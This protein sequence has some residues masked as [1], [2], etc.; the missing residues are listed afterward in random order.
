MKLENIAIGKKITLA[1]IVLALPIIFM[2]GVIVNG[3]KELNDFTKREIAGV[4]YLRP[5]QKL[6]AIMAAQPTAKNEL[7]EALDSLNK[8]EQHDAG[9]LDVTK[10][11]K[12]LVNIAQADKI[13]ESLAGI[14]DLIATISDNSNI[15]LDSDGDTYFIGDILVNQISGIMLQTRNLIK[16][17]HDLEIAKNDE[18]KIAY[19]ASQSA[20]ATGGNNLQTEL[21]KAIKA[22]KDGSVK[23]SLEAGGHEISVAIEN[24][25]QL[26][27][28]PELSLLLPASAQLHSK[29]VIF[30]ANASGLMERLLR[31][32]IASFNSSMMEDLSLSAFLTLI[33]SILSGMIILSITRPM[34]FM[35]LAAGG[36][37]EGKYH[38]AIEG[39]RRRDEIGIL[40]R[41]IDK[42]RTKIADYSGQISAIDKSQAVI[43]FNMDGTIIDANQN[44]LTTMGYN[45]DE[46]RGKHHRMFVDSLQ[47]TSGEYQ[48]FW[49]N[50]N[51][52]H[53][54]IGDVRRI[55]KD[56]REVWIRCSYNPIT[57]PD[58]KPFKVVKYAS[59]VTKVVMANLEN[60]KGMKESVQVLQDIAAG[61]LTNN[62]KEEYHGAFG[63]IKTA[64]NATIEQLKNTVSN[65][66][67]S[68]QSVNSAA[69]EISSGSKDLSERTEQ[70][71]ST[72]EQTAASME[73]MTG[74]V[75]QNTHNA[76]N[77]N[78]L[79][80]KAKEVAGKGGNIVRQVV[81]AMHYIE[82]SSKK[83]ADIIGVIDDI[84]FQTNLLA[85]NAAVE[86]ARAGDAGKGFAVVASEV[87][88]L[89]GRSALASKDIKAL[90]NSSVE[91]VASGSKL[92]NEAGTTL[93]HIEKSVDEVASL[94]SEIS[95]ASGQQ[96]TGI[97]EI[98]SAISQM[99]EMTQQNA[100]L[101]EESTAAAQSLVDQANQ[102]EKLVSA[103]II[104]G[105]QKKQ[106]PDTNS[107]YNRALA[108]AKPAPEFK[109][110]TKS[111]A[112]S[113][114]YT[115]KV[116]ASNKKVATSS[117]RYDEEWE[118][119]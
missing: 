61:N 101:V 9:G 89:A 27:K 46:I 36:L 16:A 106:Q 94:V 32:R 40:A 67:N 52:G 95:A 17:A 74:A 102:L 119:F 68:A 47:Q 64:L 76:S 55:T 107:D 86:A 51:R 56:G 98:N 28:K 34:K 90:I 111:S 87:R 79:A 45:L 104:D 69:S 13:D 15:T 6:L 60:D 5:V 73:E 53:N 108:V 23:A 10:K 3:R 66:K 81:E 33:G 38:I 62:M 29:L 70:Q 12:E 30:N 99:D 85:L 1:V 43:V 58:G 24:L 37:A 71:A 91:H 18:N 35:T 92:V 25:L 54:F 31:A 48:Q 14:S 118:E 93:T 97:E 22:N 116:P 50:L 75:R 59:D 114:S 110:S 72:L 77:A 65:I 82:D 84:A 113:A 44:L 21:L 109:T 115:K 39:D 96:A 103:F 26:S 105:N 117:R 8:A 112:K 42:I 57:G 100:A 41:A 7:A 88:S 49:E 83:I 19:A 4:E 78:E 80:A 11:T 20:I 2:G 63:D